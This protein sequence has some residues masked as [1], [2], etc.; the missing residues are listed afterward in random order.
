ML[1]PFPLSRFGWFLCLSLNCA[2]VSYQVYPLT[3]AQVT[4]EHVEGVRFNRPWPYILVGNLADAQA[5]NAAAGLGMKLIYL[6]DRSTTY[7]VRRRGAFGTAQTALT[8]E[9]GW[10]LTQFNGQS[11][12]KTPETLDALANLVKT[13]APTGVGFAKPATATAPT[14]PSPG[15]WR[16]EFDSTGTISGLRLVKPLQVN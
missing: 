11:D 7:A 15:L 14:F 5:G 1:R 2:C 8:L 6:P 9:G 10:N 16:L 13:V 12:S 4:D 3:K